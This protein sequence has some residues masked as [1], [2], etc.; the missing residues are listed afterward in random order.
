MRAGTALLGT[1]FEAPIKDK[2]GKQRYIDVLVQ[3]KAK[4][5]VQ[6]LTYPFEVKTQKLA[7]L[8]RSELNNIYFPAVECNGFILDRHRRLI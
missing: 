4:N 6:A 5:G 3:A 1:Q 7:K 8:G 2:E